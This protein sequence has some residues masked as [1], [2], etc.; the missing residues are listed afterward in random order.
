M[1]G[2]ISSG[3][4]V[5]L[6]TQQLNQHQIEQAE[7]KLHVGARQSEDAEAEMKGTLKPVRETSAGH[8]GG[9]RHARG[10]LLLRTAEAGTQQSDAVRCRKEEKA[11]NPRFCAQQLQWLGLHAFLAQGPGSVPSLGT[12]T[13][14]V[15]WS[16]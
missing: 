4:S 12:K 15:V 16:K 2:N 13:L 10:T 8:A 3:D 5:S 6:Q 9:Q 11:V 7:R 14:Q 1:P